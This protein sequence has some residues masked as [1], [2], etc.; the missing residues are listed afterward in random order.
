MSTVQ[1]GSRNMSIDSDKMATTIA[2]RVSMIKICVEFDGDEAT[3]LIHSIGLCTIA[4]RAMGCRF[5]LYVLALVF[6]T[7]LSAYDFLL[8]CLL[9]CLAGLAAWHSAVHP[10][11]PLLCG[12]LFPLA[13]MIAVSYGRH[14]WMYASRKWHVLG[15]PMWLS[16]LCVISSF[17]VTDLHR[18]AARLSVRMDNRTRRASIGPEV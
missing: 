4:R 9:G 2:S 17:C 7:S 12:T 10:F 15:L 13:D 5:V 1:D 14:T 11:F 3:L 16:P 6:V 8:F 18:C